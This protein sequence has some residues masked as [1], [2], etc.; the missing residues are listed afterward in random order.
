MFNG[1]E[2]MAHASSRSRRNDISSWLFGSLS[3]PTHTISYSKQTQR[4]QSEG[5]TGELTVEILEG[6]LYSCTL[7]RAHAFDVLQVMCSTRPDAE[8]AGG[9]VAEVATERGP[10]LTQQPYTQ[11]GVTADTNTHR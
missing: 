11:G 4:K 3:I 7:H 9:R 6:A 8:L 10:P 2:S 5:L 1:K